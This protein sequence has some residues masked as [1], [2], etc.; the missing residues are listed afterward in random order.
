[1][2]TPQMVDAIL[3]LQNKNVELAEKNKKLRFRIFELER[4]VETLE[5]KLDAA[6]SIGRRWRDMTYNNGQ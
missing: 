1:M 5:E 4:E 6:R 2:S 3:K